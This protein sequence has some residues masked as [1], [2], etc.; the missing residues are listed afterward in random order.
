MLQCPE[1]FVTALEQVLK[2]RG[3]GASQEKK[4]E[5]LLRDVGNNMTLAKDEVISVCQVRQ[6]GIITSPPS[7]A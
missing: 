5:Y 6:A 4:H 3:A 2:G 7:P 1:S